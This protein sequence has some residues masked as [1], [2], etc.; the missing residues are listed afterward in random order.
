ML[1][2]E[3]IPGRCERLVGDAFVGDDDLEL[4]AFGILVVGARES[5]GW[6]T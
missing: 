1:I 6:R 5:T 3:G 4:L 2:S